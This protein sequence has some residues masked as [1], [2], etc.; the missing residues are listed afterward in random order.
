MIKEINKKLVDF[1]N[2]SNL[3]KSSHWK[4]YLP[5]N[6]DYLNEFAHFG[7]GAY[8]KKNFKNYIYNILIKIIF[9]NTIFKTETY[10]SYK[11]VFDEINRFIDVD[12]IRHI[13][14]FEMLKKYINPKSICIIGDGKINGILG[15]HS[16]FPNAKI[17]SV[18]LPEVLINDNLIIDKT[19]IDLKKSVT[20]VEDVNTHSEDSKMF[21]IP[22]NNKRFLMNKKIELFINIVSFQ[23]MTNYEINEYFE[24]IKNNK[25]KL[26]CC[27]REYKKLPGG[28]ELYFEKYPFLNSKKLF[29]E[30][31]P[32]HQKYYSLRPPFIHK[33][34]GNIKHCLVD[35]S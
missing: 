22:S 3:N 8:T 32:W 9:G 21:L 23:E 28:E 15:A 4:K 20:L 29:W 27:N 26:Y 16:T 25:S 24:I 31:C 18:N 10:N 33:Y 5:E 12:T 34:D 17:Y 14:T 30:N 13:F 6:S 35:F 2:K 19:N 7:F 1:I 11:I